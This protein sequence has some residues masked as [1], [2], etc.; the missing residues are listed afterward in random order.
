[1]FDSRDERRNC[2]RYDVNNSEKKRTSVFENGPV[3][4]VVGVLTKRCE[5]RKR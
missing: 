4:G 3:Q 1:L 5:F 2:A